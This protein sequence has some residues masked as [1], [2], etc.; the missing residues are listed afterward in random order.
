MQPVGRSPANSAIR[1]ESSAR[2]CPFL[3]S[4][5]RLGVGPHLPL[6]APFPSHGPSLG[7]P[8][9][10]WTCL[11]PLEWPVGFSL[12]KYFRL[13]I[14]I[15]SSAPP[16]ALDFHPLNG[17]S[18]EPT[19][20]TPFP[21]RLGADQVQ[22][23]NSPSARGYGTLKLPTA[24]GALSPSQHELRRSPMRSL[25][26]RATCTSLIHCSSRTRTRSAQRQFSPPWPPGTEK[27]LS[28]PIQ[29]AQEA[30]SILHTGSWCLAAVQTSLL[31]PRQRPPSTC[32]R[33]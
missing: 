1:V 26:L 17:A 28:L 22:R 5:R 18:T 13:D 31:G 10:E 19:S 8:P 11:H 23:H 30:S 7:L 16:I 29:L 20:P 21:F 12:E 15:V 32:H 3:P 25:H 9:R 27:T 4:F 6:P 2:M 33:I 24:N 14:S